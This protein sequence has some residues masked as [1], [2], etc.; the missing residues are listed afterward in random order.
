MR[1]ALSLFVLFLTACASPGTRQSAPTDWEQHSARVQ[2]LTQW[3]ASGKLALRTPDR[4]ESANVMWQ[5]LGA[6]TRLQL[7]GPVGFNAT[8][9][10]SDGQ[11]MEM[12]QGDSVRRWDISSPD[13]IAQNTGW[14]LPLQALP[15]WL[16]GLPAPDTD[17]EL[18][19]LD[20]DQVLLQ[21]LKQDDW[22]ILFETYEQF[23]G[24][25]LPTRLRIQRGETKARMII[26]DWQA[27][28]T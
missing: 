4:S 27:I 17:I 24:I 6:H 1:L 9:I 20:P 13:A 16:R 2:A 3:S 15:H 18:M 5:Q 23:E 22:E 26:R 7:S 10:L 19:E 11:H 21:R 28:A 8:T 14:D 25:T 12:R